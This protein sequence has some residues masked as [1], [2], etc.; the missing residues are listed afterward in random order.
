MNELNRNLTGYI[1]LIAGLASMMIAH[2][3]GFEKLVETGAGLV[4]AALL[5]FQHRNAPDAPID[6]KV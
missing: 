5:A 6:P 3:T 1:L 2:H 4:G